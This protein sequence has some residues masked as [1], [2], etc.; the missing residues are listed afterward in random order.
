MRIRRRDFLRGAAAFT[1]APGQP[2]ALLW[3]A[4]TGA[5]ERPVKTNAK[6]YDVAVIGAGVFG[7]WTALRLVQGGRRVVLLDEYGPANARASSGGESRIIRAGYGPDELYARWALRSLTLWRELF[8][9]NHVDLFHNCGVLWLARE[10]DAYATQ[11]AA[12][13]AKLGVAAEHFDRAHMQRRYPQF[14]FDGVDWGLLEPQAGALM[15]RRAV[16]AV[17]AAAVA[18]GVTYL[19]ASVKTPAGKAR[20]ASIETGAGERISA[21]QYVFACGPW[22][23]KMFPDLLGER[24]FPT[25][26]EV[27]FFG[28][29]AGNAQFAM[30]AM[31]G[32]IFVAD[33]VY[34][35]PDLEN[36]GFKIALDRHGERVDPDTQSRIVA[37]ESAEWMRSYVAR[38]FPGLRDAPIIETRVCQYEN[39]SNG[40]FLVDRHPQ[41]ENVWLV[42]G[43]SGHGFKHGPALGEYVAGQVLG[44]GTAIELRFSL[45][46]KHSVQ[47]RTVY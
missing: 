42:G 17:A 34:G 3:E 45:A 11:T 36:R 43:G 5:G 44:A 32:W 12:T 4:T 39:T 30:P 41:M 35:V 21:G 33:G 27:F 29:P 13:L 8:S 22:L 18:N 37:K 40:D 10:E 38:R 7:S 25:R 6:T 16:Q 47:K 20:L 19:Q 24:I 26:Q 23:G 1:M 9:A 15:A 46:T 28:A 14:N 2:S 31:P